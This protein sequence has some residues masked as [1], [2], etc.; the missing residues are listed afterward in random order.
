M[1]T[2][3]LVFL[4]FQDLPHAFPREG[5]KHIA[6]NDRVTGELTSTTSDG[7]VEPNPVAYGAARFSPRG[8]IHAETLVKGAARAIIVELK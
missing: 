8:R 2:L 3:L 6:E 1:T 5:V 4:L 7:K